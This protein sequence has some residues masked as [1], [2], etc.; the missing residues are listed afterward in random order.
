M[1]IIE[2]NSCV[3]NARILGAETFV[4]LGIDKYFTTFQYFYN[5]WFCQ[6]RILYISRYSQNF[7]YVRR[8][9]GSD[10]TNVNFSYVE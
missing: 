7:E 9:L 4:S 2:V 6:N 10:N 8:F 3:R 5:I 1:M